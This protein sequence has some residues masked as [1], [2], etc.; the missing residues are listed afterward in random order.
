MFYSP[1]QVLAGGPLTDLIQLI[2]A[3]AGNVE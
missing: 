2:A 3:G 1:E